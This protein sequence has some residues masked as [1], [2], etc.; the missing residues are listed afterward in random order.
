MVQDIIN[1]F[2]SEVLDK[3][4]T[5]E[6]SIIHGDFNEQNIL[7]EKAENGSYFVSGVIDFGDTQ[8]SCF[9]FE[10]AISLTYMMF[11]SE[12]VENGGYF[13]DGYE[14]FRQIPE[15]EKKVLRVNFEYQY[16]RKSKLIQFFIKSPDLL[17]RAF[18]PVSFIGIIYL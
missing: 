14:K 11:C 4:D 10:V 5:F 7:V 8:Y 17:L 15:H 12:K 1:K 13:L 9:L 2:Q 3:Y 16:T 18:M 6:K